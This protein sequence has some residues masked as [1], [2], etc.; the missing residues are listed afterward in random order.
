MDRIIFH[1]DVNNA[2][3]SW[4]AV[5]LLQKGYKKDIR[6]ECAVIG[7]DQSKRRGVVLA[8]SNIAKQKGIMTG[9]SLYSA[10]KKYSELKVYHPQY[11][12]YQ[13]MSNN[14]FKFL[15][16]YSPDIEVFSIDECFIDYGKV[17]RLYGDEVEFA[18]KIK[19]EIKKELGFTVNIGIGN[20][21]LCAKMASDFEKPDKVHTLYNNEVKEKMW[22]LTVNSL[23]GIG[24]KSTEQL[25]KINIYTI[26]DLANADPNKLVKYFKNQS[27]EM[28]KRANGIDDSEVKFNKEEQKGIS[29]SITLEQDINSKEEAYKVLDQLA[30]N[31]GVILRKKNKYTLVIAVNLK[32]CYFQFLFSSKEIKKCN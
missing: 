31:L 2:F 18:Y 29:Q 3:L 20:N 7:G 22:P 8:K 23:I 24:K 1:I 12:V 32:D 13:L 26:S 4:S 21:K 10:K 17:K 27:S 5:D 19:E 14:L 25:N 30:D 9:E 15:D 28:I 11:E 16:N 6:K